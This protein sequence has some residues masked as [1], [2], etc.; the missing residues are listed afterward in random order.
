M[1]RLSLLLLS[2]VA[3]NDGKDDTDEF[4]DGSTGSGTGDT[5]HATSCDDIDGDG[6]TVEDGDC[7]DSDAAVYLGATEVCDGVD[8]NCDGSID[9]G[10]LSTWY[11]DADGDAFGNPSASMDSCTAPTGM[12]A[13]AS[14]CDDLNADAYPGADEIC[15]GADD[16]CDGDIDENA[17]DG[18]PFYA[19]ADDDGYGDPGA[20]S[21]TCTPA[22][23][24]VANADDCDDTDPSVFPGSTTTEIP[25]DGI[26]ADCDGNDG[27]TDLNCDGQPDIFNVG[28]WDDDGSYGDA[29]TYLYYGA[30]FLD[31]DRT[32]LSTLS[33][34]VGGAEDLNQD[35]YIDL[36]VV[37][38]YAGGT[39]YV[40]SNVYWGSATGYSDTDRTDLDT[41]G[42]TYVLLEDLDADGWTD[43]AFANASTGGNSG[44]KLDSTIYWGSASGY[45]A[46]DR[47]DLPTYGA[48]EI[49]AGDIDNDG[50][51]DIVICNFYDDS[52]GGDY[53][54]DSVIYWGDA[55]RFSTLTTTALP[56]AGCRSVEVEDFDGDGLA[57]VVFANSFD[58]AYEYQIDSVVYWN[59]ND[60]FS[61]LTTTGL[62]TSWTHAVEVEDM[63]GDGDLDLL[64][65][66]LYG[67]SGYAGE[68]YVY[69]NDGG[70][71]SATDR[72][73][74][75]TDGAYYIYA[76]DLNGDGY[77]EVIVPA[78]WDDDT[79]NET[80]STVTWGS[81]SGPCGTSTT[82]L[83]TLAP[84]GADFADL[85]DDGFID[86]V[87][88]SASYATR[89]SE[90]YIYWGSACGY[91]DVD[92]TPFAAGQGSLE[93]PFIVGD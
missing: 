27:C 14:D 91:D 52:D 55:D 4:T 72:C 15:N 70:S 33:G 17:V 2:L 11:Q 3:C 49:K 54:P 50:E 56:T 26:D 69:W 18:G 35:G 63:D 10:V 23:G 48:W 21:T 25:G 76:E 9:E 47:T 39:R 12:V 73:E 5:G 87:F 43:L 42:S 24:V 77:S 45:S 30:D 75:P 34:S 41:I 89:D 65:G 68:S 57:D 90:S 53:E 38:T 93:A 62:P 37:N 32:E 40:S 60:R 84:I 59:D 64:F 85:N 81:A 86:L 80:W 29:D 13:D 71:F 79:E 1:L 6:V 66:S 88:S 83:P 36:V 7:N 61:V 22:S 44:F 28:Y 58:N 51:T 16:N 19:D 78:S 20:V 8:N 82:A 31:G 46:G 74:I 67:D 92:V